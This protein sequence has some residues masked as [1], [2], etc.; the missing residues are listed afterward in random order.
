MSEGIRD[1]ALINAYQRMI[2][3]ATVREGDVKLQQASAAFIDRIAIAAKR[4]KAGVFLNDGMR[5]EMSRLADEFYYEYLASRMPDITASREIFSSAYA[6]PTGD[7]ILSDKEVTDD[8]ARVVP[9]GSYKRWQN[10]LENNKHL[11]FIEQ[12]ADIEQPQ[13]VITPAEYQELIAAAQEVDLTIEE[14][15]EMLELERRKAAGQ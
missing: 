1:I 2:D 9:Q 15:L 5:A 14:Y 13:P 4:I 6:G 10:F 8:F 3:P 12:P 7:K 11:E